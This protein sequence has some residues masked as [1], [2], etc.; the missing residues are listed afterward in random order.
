[1]ILIESSRS[2]FRNLKYLFKIVFVV[3]AED[4]PRNVKL[5]V[6]LPDVS[7]S[8]V[9]SDK[10]MFEEFHIWW[11]HTGQNIH[12]LRKIALIITSEIFVSYLLIA[13]F[14]ICIALNIINYKIGFINFFESIYI[15]L[16]SGF[17]STVTSRLF[18]YLNNKTLSTFFTLITGMLVQYIVTAGFFIVIVK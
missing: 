10:V 6:L 15:A 5:I 13:S 4:R 11:W 12:M 1:M 16:L 8:V 7:C 3:M 17:V 2:V 14:F 18:Y 9:V